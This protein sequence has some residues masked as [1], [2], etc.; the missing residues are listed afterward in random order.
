MNY[1]DTHQVPTLQ[2]SQ[3]ADELLGKG[4]IRRPYRTLTPIE[5]VTFG[6]SNVVKMST[7]FH[8]HIR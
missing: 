1:P 8:T 4:N 3:I 5:E 7:S 6:E 2:R